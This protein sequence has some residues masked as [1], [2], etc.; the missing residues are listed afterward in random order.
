[1]FNTCKVFLGNRGTNPLFTNKPIVR[2]LILT[3]NFVYS[4]IEKCEE[5]R[6]WQ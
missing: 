1:M 6:K 4:R 3:R 2:R 5:N